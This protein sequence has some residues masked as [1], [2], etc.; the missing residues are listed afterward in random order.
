LIKQETE[1]EKEITVFQTEQDRIFSTLNN[2]KTLDD[3]TLEN[4]NV[5]EFKDETN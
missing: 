4:F 3:K 5:K 2:I 1:I